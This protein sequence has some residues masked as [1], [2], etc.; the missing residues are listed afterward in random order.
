[1]SD[2]SNDSAESDPVPDRRENSIK[3]SI[4]EL[5]VALH[6]PKELRQYVFVYA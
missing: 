2:D 6:G 5:T 3:H 1:M 4:A